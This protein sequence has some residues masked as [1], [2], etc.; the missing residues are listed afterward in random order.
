MYS[1]C[2]EDCRDL[3]QYFGLIAAFG[4]GKSWLSVWEETT[5]MR[6]TR[7]PI[8]NSSVNNQDRLDQRLMI[9][10]CFILYAFFMCQYFTNFNL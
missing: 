5:L 2:V 10:V 3:D 1:F 4:W 7:R 9:Q 6:W 8:G